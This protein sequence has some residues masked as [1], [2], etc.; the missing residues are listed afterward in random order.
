[1]TRFHRKAPANRSP[2]QRGLGTEA[3]HSFLILLFNVTPVAEPLG[4]A[5]GCSPYGLYEFRDPIL[6]DTVKRS[7]YPPMKRSYGR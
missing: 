6:S 3:P 7:T 1:M 2:V 5:S 4:D